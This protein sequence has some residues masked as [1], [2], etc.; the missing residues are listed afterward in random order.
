VYHLKG[1]FLNNVNPFSKCD[2]ILN[3]IT[4]STLNLEICNILTYFLLLSTELDARTKMS[5][6]QVKGIFPGAKVT[7][8]VDWDWGNQVY[9]IIW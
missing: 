1:N 8:G 4:I 9:I 3:I 2:I 5:K 7:R 6:V